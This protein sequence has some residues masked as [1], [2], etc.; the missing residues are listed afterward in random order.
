MNIPQPVPKIFNIYTKSKCSYCTKAKE[1]FPGANIINCDT[2]WKEDKRKF[3]ETMDKLSGKQ[4]RT[5]PM[6]FNGMKYIGG[7]EDTKDLG[8]NMN[9]SF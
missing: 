5:F 4:P 2:Y 1:N 3:L 6:I 8:F 7:F 9:T